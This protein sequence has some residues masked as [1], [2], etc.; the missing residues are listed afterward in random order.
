M[1]N[2]KGEKMKRAGIVLLILAGA[3]NCS[4]SSYAAKGSVRVYNVSEKEVRFI[5]VEATLK[6]N[7]PE[8]IQLAA[9]SQSEP[10]TLQ[11]DNKEMH[12]LS[13]AVEILNAKKPKYKFHLCTVRFTGDHSA[14]YIDGDPNLV[15]TKKIGYGCEMR[16]EGSKAYLEVFPTVYS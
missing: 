3:L 2:S 6:S 12:G 13:L 16:V 10:Y 15:D 1:S 4:Q 9:R 14:E 5:T 11:F 7:F 8:E